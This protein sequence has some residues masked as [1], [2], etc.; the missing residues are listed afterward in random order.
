MARY[1]NDDLDNFMMWCFDMMHDEDF[2]KMPIHEQR[3]FFLEKQKD[4]DKQIEIELEHVRWNT[5]EHF[6]KNCT[7]S[8]DDDY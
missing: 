1:Q 2:H 3:A 4:L 7:C 8:C 6:Q 5:V